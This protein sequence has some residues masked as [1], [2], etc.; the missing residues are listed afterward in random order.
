[1][2]SQRYSKQTNLTG[3]SW[4]LLRNYLILLRTSKYKMSLVLT[5]Q[6]VSFSLYKYTRQ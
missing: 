5:E 1:M 6:M 3:Y 2:G 4:S